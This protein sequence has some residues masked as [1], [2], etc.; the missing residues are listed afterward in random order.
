MTSED[1]NHVLNKSN[2]PELLKSERARYSR[3]LLLPEVGEEGQR[4]LKA[5]KVLLVGAG[6]LGSP[7]ALYLAAA[8]VG[9][10]GIIDGDKVDVTNL[11]RQILYGTADVGA[12]KAVTAAKTLK[13][14]NPEISFVTYSERLTEHNALELVGSYDMVLDGTDNF[15]TRYLVNDACVFKKRPNV[16]GSIFRFEGQSSVF[17]TPNGPCY[18]CLFPDPPA[19]DEVPNCAEAGVLGVLAGVIGTIQ[20]TEAI[21]WILRLGNSLAGHL[22]I[23]DAIGMEF[24]KLKIRKR[25]DCPLCGKEPTIT[26]LEESAV[27]CAKQLASAQAG[28]VKAETAELACEIEPVKLAKVLAGSNPPML[29]DVRNPEEYQI[30]NL[31]NSVLIPLP[32]LE[33]RFTELPK[34][35]EMVVYCR[36]GNRSRRAI[37]VLRNKGFSKLTNLAGG[38]SAW[39]DQVDSSMPKY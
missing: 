4:K 34:D 20:A 5:A 9:T 12:K 30:C 28:G 25:D 36:S 23:Y 7:A 38:I 6:G 17:C 33:T 27:L 8:G 24:T 15:G 26:D 35:K 11:Q 37:D 21:K 3:H 32:E 19:P 1:S 29:L 22:L 18:R 13:K 10:I 31:E 2:H 14:L 16:Y 39:A